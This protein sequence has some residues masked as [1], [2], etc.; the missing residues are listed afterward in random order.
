[1][2]EKMKEYL[3]KLGIIP[4]YTEISIF[5]IGLTVVF[6]VI[7]NLNLSDILKFFKDFWEQETTLDFILSVSSISILILVWLYAWFLSIYH[8]FSEKEVTKSDKKMMLDFTIVTITAVGMIASIHILS[9]SKG[10]WVIFPIFNFISVY[11][12][13]LLLNELR[14]RGII[15]TTDVIIVKQAKREEV[16]VG[17]IAVFI[18][19]FISNYIFKNHWSITFSICTSYAALFNEMITKLFFKHGSTKI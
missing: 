6:I 19:F 16:I 11:I 1:M 12:S 5:L 14:K 17:T 4:Q 9:E 13:F 8:I 18:L 3:K 15:T 7:G 2:K 10:I